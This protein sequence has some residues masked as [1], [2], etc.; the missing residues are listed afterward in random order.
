MA[1][2]PGESAGGPRTAQS[3]IKRGIN[4]DPLEKWSKEGLVVYGHAPPPRAN[5]APATAPATPGLDSY[6]HA[7][8]TR[9]IGFKAWVVWLSDAGGGAWVRV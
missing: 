7:Q 6:P 9:G 4:V 2:E 5:P 8:G 3:L 1:P